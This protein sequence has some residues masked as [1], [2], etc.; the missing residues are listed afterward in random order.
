MQKC[1][2]NKLNITDDNNLYY[3][4]DIVRKYQNNNMKVIMTCGCFSILH[5]GH[6]E[7]LKLGRKCG[8]Y[9]IVGLNSDDYIRKNKYYKLFFN[10]EER[11]EMITE[12]KCVDAAFVFY[13]STF[14]KALSIIVPDIFIKGPEYL[15]SMNQGEY[16]V[17][18]ENNIEIRFIGDVKKYNS[19]E[20]LNL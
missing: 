13:E 20:I 9:L 18:K 3:L 2:K 10:Q 19:S 1:F 16:T 12:L 4:R 17:C 8:D 15:T 5:P 6:I 7:F 11:M 14:E